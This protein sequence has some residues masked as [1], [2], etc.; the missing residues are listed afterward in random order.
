MEMTAD[1]GLPQLLEVVRWRWKFVAW[2]AIL[3]ALGATLYVETLPSRYD[4]AAVVA[5][6]PRANAANSG[7]ETVRVVV[8]KYVEY[9]TADATIRRVAAELRLDHAILSNAVSAKHAQLTG[10]VTITVRLEEPARAAKAANSFAT[11]AIEYSRKDPLLVGE[12]VA[13]AATPSEPSAPPRRILEA[14]ALFVGILLGLAAAALVERG[15]PRLR[16]WRQITELTGHPVVGRIPRSRVVSSHFYEGFRDPSIASAFRTLRANIEPQLREK[17][18]DILAITSALR[19]DGKTTIAALLAEALSRRDFRVLLVDADMRRAALSEAIGFT[20][21]GFGF[22]GMLRDTSSV[23]TDVQQGWAPNLS[24]LPTARVENAGDLLA[25]GFDGV[26]AKLRH[27]HDLVVIDCPPLLG[28]E[29]TRSIAPL[30]AGVLLVVSVG[31]DT[32]PVNEAV[33]TLEALR[34]PLLGVVANR[35]RDSGVM[36]GDLGA[37]DLDLLPLPAAQS[38][39]PWARGS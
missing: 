5:F 8:P 36:Y 2:I 1:R 25:R 18:L 9:V 24:V 32:E 35:V 20:S 30:A 4:G 11:A 34:A 26:R 31:S 39:S 13:A 6:A 19:T 10:N 27:Q 33:L 14:T 12:L 17:E 22:A 21:R 37:A 23:L 29:D 28:L 7:A 16:D 3:M 15:R 38:S